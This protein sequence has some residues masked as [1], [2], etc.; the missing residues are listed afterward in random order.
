MF[1]CVCLHPKNGLLL[2]YRIYYTQHHSTPVHTSLLYTPPSPHLAPYPVWALD[3]PLPPCSLSNLP[4]MTTYTP[5]TNIDRSIIY[6]K[7]PT[8]SCTHTDT[9]A[10]SLPNSTE[11]L[12]TQQLDGNEKSRHGKKG[13]MNQTMKRK[14]RT[15]P[16]TSLSL[17]LSKKSEEEKKKTSE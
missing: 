1:V 7:K 15:S 2:I 17:S 14:N 9:H 8:L 11:Q 3:P 13:D 12:P 5:A 6:T 10:V 4:F 16:E